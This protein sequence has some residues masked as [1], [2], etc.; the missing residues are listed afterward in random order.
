MNVMNAS[1]GKLPF[2]FIDHN[3][4]QLLARKEPTITGELQLY[5]FQIPCFVIGAVSK[6]RTPQKRED[7]LRQFLAEDGSV[8][9]C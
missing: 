5:E 4:L 8:H 9:R 2:R 3:Q 7:P 6:P 1:I